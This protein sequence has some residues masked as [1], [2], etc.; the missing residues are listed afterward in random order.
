MPDTDDGSELEKSVTL[1]A[2]KATAELTSADIQLL[3]TAVEILIFTDVEEGE[4]AR[5]MHR[6][7]KELHELMER[8]SILLEE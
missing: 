6:V 3:E 4:Q 1:T 2:G 5:D 8:L 7:G